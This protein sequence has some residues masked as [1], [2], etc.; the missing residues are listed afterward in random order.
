MQKLRYTI[1][2]LHFPDYLSDGG[3]CRNCTSPVESLIIMCDKREIFFCYSI[4]EHITHEKSAQDCHG[5]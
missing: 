3:M 4:T 5:G 2:R 1:R